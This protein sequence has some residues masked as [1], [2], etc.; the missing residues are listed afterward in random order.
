MRKLQIALMP[1]LSWLSCKSHYLV[2]RYINNQSEM[3]YAFPSLRGWLSWECLVRAWIRDRFWMLWLCRILF[4]V[5]HPMFMG[6][7]DICTGYWIMSL[8]TNVKPYQMSV[9]LIWMHVLLFYPRRINYV[10]CDWQNP[11]NDNSANPF[12]QL[13]FF[14]WGY[15]YM[16]VVMSMIRLSLPI[17]LVRGGGLWPVVY[18]AVRF[19]ET[20]KY[21]VAFIIRVSH[22]WKHG[23]IQFLFFSTQWCR[24]WWS[25]RRR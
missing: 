3:F 10:S 15:D 1:W 21:P 17:V 11:G 9:C 14:A 7:Y 4:Y 5:M 19:S 23:A 20:G 18:I 12:R 16:C 25:I 24:L 22:Y 2:C 13:L 8:K 6:V